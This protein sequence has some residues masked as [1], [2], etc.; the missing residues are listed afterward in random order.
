MIPEY[1]KASAEALGLDVIEWHR[2]N[3]IFLFRQVGKPDKQVW[4][5]DKDANQREM[6]EDWLMNEKDLCIRTDQGSCECS[7]LIYGVPI[8]G[9]PIG[10]TDTTKSTAF[11]KVFMRFV[12][13]TK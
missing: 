6:I 3:L 10:A 7:V 1:R 13:T 2:D 4:Q 9:N 11:M 8:Y 5:P 12:K